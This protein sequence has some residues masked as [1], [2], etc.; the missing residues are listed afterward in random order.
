V[1]DTT[2]RRQAEETLPKAQ[3]ELAHVTRM[4]TLGEQTVSLAHERPDLEEAMG[5][6]RR[7]IR[8][9][10]RARGGH[11]GDAGVRAEISRG[12]SVLLDLAAVIHDV[13][14]LVQPEALKH[15]VALTPATA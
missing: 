11:R 12:E 5:A 14:I 15:R 4:T 6:V 13:L 3:A 8:D 7:I 1:V 2:E 10:N 9:G